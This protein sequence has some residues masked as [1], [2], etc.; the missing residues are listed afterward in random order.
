VRVVR[1]TNGPVDP[2]NGDFIVDGDA[3][4]M[5]AARDHRVVRVRTVGSLATADFGTDLES[6]GCYACRQASRSGTRAL[7][8]D[9]ATYWAL[10]L[11]R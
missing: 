5:H 8:Q 3:V 4:S 11:Q 2:A 1:T 6:A 7:A 10:S 9:G